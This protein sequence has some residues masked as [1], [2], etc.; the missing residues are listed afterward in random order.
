MLG[1]ADCV[2]VVR[3]FNRFYTRLIGLLDRHFLD[4]PY[5]LT[6]VRVLYE[7]ARMKECTAREIKDRLGTDEGYLSRIVDAFIRKGIAEKA[8]SP[9]DRRRHI[10]RL[11]SKGRLVFAELDAR[12]NDSIARILE[13]LPAGKLE[14]L[15]AALERAR[16]ILGDA[17]DAEEES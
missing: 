4:S 13:R 17:V 8:P 12:S 5:S 2:S 14:E 1:K 15:A 10:I 16:R 6:Q 3:G 7:M 11:T 9:D